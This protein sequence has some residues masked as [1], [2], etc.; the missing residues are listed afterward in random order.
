VGGQ[1][2]WE[3]L[4]ELQKKCIRLLKDAEKFVGHADTFQFLREIDLGRGFDYRLECNGFS[5]NGGEFHLL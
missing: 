4:D 1:F 2:T 5:R 3:Q